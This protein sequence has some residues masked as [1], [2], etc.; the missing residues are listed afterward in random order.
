M[1]QGVEVTLPYRVV[2]VGMGKRGMHHATAFAGNL[3]FDLVGVCS[4]DPKRLADAAAKLGNVR[5]ST[6]AGTLARDAKPDVFC[7]C[8]PPGVRLPLVVQGVDSGAKLI[9]LE[10]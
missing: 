3:R 9:A 10:K 8:T 6:D 5:T 4:R 7:F 2:V 1:G